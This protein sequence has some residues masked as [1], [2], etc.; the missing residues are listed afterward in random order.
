MRHMLFVTWVYIIRPTAHTNLCLP[1]QAGIIKRKK[2]AS[3][4]KGNKEEDKHIAQV[5]LLMKR[6]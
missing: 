1:R 5:L 4:K 3:K 6:M 2:N